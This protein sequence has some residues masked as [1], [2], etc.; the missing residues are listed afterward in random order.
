M[1]TCRSD[2]SLSAL[3]PWD[4]AVL[5]STEGGDLLTTSVWGTCFWH[6][7]NPNP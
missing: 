2:S 6:L 1:L 5:P 4:A 7:E 3:L